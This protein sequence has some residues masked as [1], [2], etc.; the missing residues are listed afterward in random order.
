MTTNDPEAT[1]EVAVVDKVD[2]AA[3][4][5]IVTAS[6]ERLNKIEK[7]KRRLN[8]KKSVTTKSLKRL[9]TAIESF[10]ESTGKVET[11]MTLADKNLVKSDAKEVLE[12][13]DKAQENRKDLETLSDLLQ[14]ALNECEPTEIQKGVTQE[15]AM[16]K[17]DSEVY[18][19]ID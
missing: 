12:S 5:Q 19:Y 1:G 11:A 14:E 16:R 15:D 7:L 18:D 3:V 6:N 9:D 13:R 4:V 2:T 17:V 8:S 10:R